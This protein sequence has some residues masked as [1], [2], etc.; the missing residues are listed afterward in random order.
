MPPSSELKNRSVAR[1]TLV[2]RRDRSKGEFF[3]GDNLDVKRPDTGISPMQYWAWFK[4]TA[5]RDY[6]KN[7][8]IG[9]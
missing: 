9:I 7:E 6:K 4:R 8:L 2:A 1:K 3:S 5:D